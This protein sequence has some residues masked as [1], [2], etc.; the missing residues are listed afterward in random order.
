MYSKENTQ[1]KQYQINIAGIERLV[2]VTPE[3]P[4]AKDTK[5]RYERLI[6]KLILL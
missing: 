3:Q 5:S 6:G 1:T 2:F 4:I